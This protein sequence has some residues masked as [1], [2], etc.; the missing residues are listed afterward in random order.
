MARQSQLAASVRLQELKRFRPSLKTSMVPSAHVCEQ[1]AELVAGPVQRFVAVVQIVPAGQPPAQGASPT[2]DELKQRRPAAQ[3]VSAEQE[4]KVQP[5]P[6]GNSP[7]CG[8][9]YSPTAGQSL[10]C[11]QTT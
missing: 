5:G 9:Q 2:H 7:S 11:W 8:S 1:L 3:S 4:R 10:S 6:L